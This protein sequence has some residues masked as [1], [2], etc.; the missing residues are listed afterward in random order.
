MYRQ[1]ME[2]GI[3]SKTCTKCAETKP[4]SDFYKN[5]SG[6]LGLGS[7]CKVCHRELA[8]STRVGTST[9]AWHVWK[10]NNIDHLREYRRRLHKGRKDKASAYG[11]KNHLKRKFNLSSDEYSAMM[12]SQDG[13]CAICGLPSSPGKSLAVDHNHTT[14][15]IRG[16]LCTTCNLGLGSFKDNANLLQ[17][18][19]EYLLRYDER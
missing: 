19:S 5:K 16:L 6:K 14:G 1:K 13:K 3:T 8:Y 11:R 2:Q 12:V 4:L 18:A 7:R 15:K 17:R 9:A 10:E